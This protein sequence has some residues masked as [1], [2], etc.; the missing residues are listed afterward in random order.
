MKRLL[1]DRGSM[2]LTFNIGVKDWAL[3]TEPSGPRDSAD[4]EAGAF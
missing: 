3:M 1:K 2:V 4:S